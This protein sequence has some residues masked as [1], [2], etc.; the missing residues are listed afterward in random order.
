MRAMERI[1]IF[2]ASGHA[3]VVADAIRRAGTFD[4]AGFVDQVS[5]ARDGQTFFG[6]HVHT[7][8]G[9]LQRFLDDGITRAFVAIGDCSAR[10]RIADSLSL[11][12]FTLPILVHPSAVIA[13]STRLGA[14]TFVAAGAVIGP[15]CSIGQHVIINTRASVD[16][17]CEIQEGVHVC[18]GVSLAGDVCIKER[19]WAGIGATVIEKLTI[20][21]RCFIA[22]GSVVTGDLA[23]ESRVAGCPARPIARR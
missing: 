11:M 18:P 14:G 8:G 21:T 3:K 12:G 19:T 10:I 1:V 13:E 16:H 5:L 4:I 23:S 9:A 20:G 6:S 22:A 17:D 15:D 7:D 2:G